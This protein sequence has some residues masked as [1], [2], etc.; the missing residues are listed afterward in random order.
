MRWERTMFDYFWTPVQ[1]PAWPSIIFFLWYFLSLFLNIIFTSVQWPAFFSICHQ[2]QKM[3]SPRSSYLFAFCKVMWFFSGLD[4]KMA[5]FIASRRKSKSKVISHKINFI[6]LN[7]ICLWGFLLRRVREILSTSLRGNY[8]IR[9]SRT[10][11]LFVPDSL[12]PIEF[13]GI[14]WLP[15]RLRSTKFLLTMGH[16]DNYQFRMIKN[17]SRHRELNM[18]QYSD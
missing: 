6:T 4:M 16:S 10:I 15:E 1:W 12:Y 18:K 2:H 14:G 3:L 8:L 17:I 13:T 5:R 11:W 7:F 9:D